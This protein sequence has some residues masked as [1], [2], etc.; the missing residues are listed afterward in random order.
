MTGRLIRDS[1]GGLPYE[2]VL[3]IARQEGQLEGDAQR[4]LSS[5]E[6]EAVDDMPEDP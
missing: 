1:G 3:P 5:P 6:V 2:Q 4:L